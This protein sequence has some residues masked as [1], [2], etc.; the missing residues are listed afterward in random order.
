MTLGDRVVV[1][2]LSPPELPEWAPRVRVLEEGVDYPLGDERFRIDHGDDYFAFFQRLGELEYVVASL[3]GEL[4]GVLAA[5]RRVIHGGVA[6]YLCDLKVSER[7]RGRLLA[8]RMVE[9]LTSRGDVDRGYGISM[10]PAGTAPNRVIRL[11]AH[12][13]SSEISTGPTLHL[14]SLDAGAMAALL[15]VLIDVRGPASFLSLRGCKDIVLG[16]TGAPMPLLH[17]QHGPCAETGHAAPIEGHV[18]MFCVPAGDELDAAVARAAHRPSGTAT[19]LHAGMSDVDWAFV[20]TS[21]I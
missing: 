11:A 9:C 4:L 7:G 16:S 18:H 8:R 6:W 20:L 1:R 10:N 19:V 2:R 17:V 13:G 15:P 21:D 14:Y 5:T 3:G 12:F